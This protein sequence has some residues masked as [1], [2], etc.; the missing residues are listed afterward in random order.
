MTATGTVSGATVTSSGTV[1]GAIVTSSGNMTATGAVS[2]SSFSSTGTVSTTGVISTTNNTQ[3]TTSTTGSIVTAGGI[4]VGRDVVVGGNLFVK[5]CGVAAGGGGNQLFVS[6]N[7]D[8]MFLRPTIN[9]NVGEMQHTPIPVSYTHLTLPTTL[10]EC[11]SRW[12]PYH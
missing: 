12:S 3:S 7:A 9:S 1:S 4:G 2:G 6:A 8:T 11:R 5:S 10:H